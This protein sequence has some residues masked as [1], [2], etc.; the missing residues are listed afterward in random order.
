MKLKPLLAIASCLALSTCGVSERD[1][2]LLAAGYSYRCVHTIT[3]YYLWYVGDVPIW[4]P[5]E[6]CNQRQWVCVREG[7]CDRVQEID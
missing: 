7:G 2:D 1:R 3:S 5:M 4:M 6:V